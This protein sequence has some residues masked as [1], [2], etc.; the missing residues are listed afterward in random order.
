MRFV[1]GTGRAVGKR[2]D[3][4]AANVLDSER[5]PGARKSRIHKGEVLLLQAPETRVINLY[6]P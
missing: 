4:A 1:L 6:A 5:S 3:N 2:N